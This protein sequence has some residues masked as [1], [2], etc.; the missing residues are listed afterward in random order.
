MDEK[1]YF[2]ALI[3]LHQG[4]E[5]QG[6]GDQVFSREILSNL[7]G[8]PKAPRIADMGCGSGAGTLIL[9][10]KFRTTIRAVDFSRKF[11]DELEVEARKQDLDQFIEVIECDMGK[12][13]WAPKSIDLLWSEGAA[14]IL[15]FGGALKAWRP[16]MADDGIAVI[17]EL[18]YFTDEVPEPLKAY[19]KK[20]YPTIK[21][22]SGNAQIAKASNFE[23]LET[24]RLPSSAWWEHYYNP[25]KE[26]IKYLRG[27]EDS[28]M[29]FVIKETEEE[30][31]LFR[32]Y[33]EF[34]GYSFYVMKAI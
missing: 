25:L 28:T 4:L 31:Q 22:E 33:E 10:E 16:L 13:N 20:M 3:A 26:N 7:K 15:T 2:Q 21:T 27:S 6:P 23:V 19:M 1:E 11:L 8:L 29:Q 24:L 12:I 34:Y 18:S 5:R 17:S 9:A 32:K 14:Y 30:M